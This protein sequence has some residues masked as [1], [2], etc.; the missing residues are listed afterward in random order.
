MET[1][2]ILKADYLDIL[3]D[4]RNKQYGSYT[5]RKY[6]DRR[7]IQSFLM[8]AGLMLAF[9][10][11]TMIGKEKPETIIEEFDIPV[12]IT[13]ILPDVKPP[14]PEPVSQPEPSGTAATIQNSV[15]VVT[16]DEL[17]TMSPPPVDSFADREPGPATN[18]S[19]PGVTHVVNSTTT[20]TGVAPVAHP[21]ATIHDYVEVI[22][23]FNGDMYK[24]LRETIKYPQAAIRNGV[25]GKVIV[26]F[27]VNE[28]GRISHAKVAR[29]I[30][31][32]CDEEAV[33]VVNSMP[34]WKPGKQNGTAVKVNFSLPIN[35]RLQ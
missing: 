17:V 13:E 28:D 8:M 32:G 4:N 20:G 11:W 30:G 1:N 33:R 34:A 25:Q 29:G 5:L 3:F 10:I 2:E 21:P 16:P 6:E 19:E 26:Q 23:S 7:M 27:V 22:P 18:G 24:F 14:A 31:A 35:F 9:C 15:P 12:I